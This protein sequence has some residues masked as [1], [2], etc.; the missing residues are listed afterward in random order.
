MKTIEQI[1][2]GIGAG[3]ANGIIL[4]VVGYAKN[5][6]QGEDFD[7]AKL[8]QTAVVGCVVGGAAGYGGI[9]YMQSYEWL[10]SMGVITLVE[11]VKKAIIR[12]LKPLIWKK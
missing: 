11:C 5:R 6:P 1:L 10:G 8:L 4:A 7:K 12:N 3:A 2:I 9:T